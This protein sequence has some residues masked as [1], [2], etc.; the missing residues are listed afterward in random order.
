MTD[1]KRWART[2]LSGYIPVMFTPYTDEGAIDEAAVRDDVE[3]TLRLPGVG[4]LYVGSVWQEFWLLTVAERKRLTEIVLDAVAGRV[5]VAVSATHT[6][7]DDAVDLAAHAAESG[8]GMIMLWPPFFGPRG[9]GGVVAFFD[10]VLGRVPAPFG[11][12]NTSLSEIGYEMDLPLLRELAQRPQIA[13]LLDGAVRLD[14][15]LETLEAIGRDVMVTSPVEEYFLVARMLYP[16]VAP[17]VLMGSSR[18]LFL[19]TPRQPYLHEF[20][21]AVEK[22]QWHD[23]QKRLGWI[24]AAGEFAHGSV[25]REGKTPLGLIKAIRGAYGQSGGTPRVPIPAPSEVEVGD[26]VSNLRAAGLDPL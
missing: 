11:F 1:A 5:P 15:F 10:Y 25:L 9:H 21:V 4:G 6:A 18:A 23:A 19:Q 12:Y 13:L 26:A 2:N 20:F 17:D 3:Y 7:P 8:A 24:M 16:E 14:V 22:G